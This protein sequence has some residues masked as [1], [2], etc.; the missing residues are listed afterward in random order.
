MRKH[1]VTSD[2]LVAADVVTADGTYVRASD[3]EHPDLLWG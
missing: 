2:N 3:Q 1:G